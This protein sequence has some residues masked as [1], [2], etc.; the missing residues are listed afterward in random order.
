MS[1]DMRI[2]RDR[3]ALSDG[4]M[5]GR[6][7]RGIAPWKIFSW[8][9]VMGIMGLAIWQFKSIQPQVLAL[10]NIS[11]TATPP[12][13]VYWKTAELAYWRGDLTT[14]IAN[15]RQAVKQQPRNVDLL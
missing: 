10:V 9:V 8:I 1:N 2:R 7:R 14:A 13:Q 6:R 4:S 5:F 12:A 3:S 15:Y 11:A